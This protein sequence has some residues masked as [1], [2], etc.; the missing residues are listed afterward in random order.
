MSVRWFTPK[1]YTYFL[2][3]VPILNREPS[4]G[5]NIA[6]QYFKI[7]LSCKSY[8]GI[9]ERS[10][11]VLTLLS[12]EYRLFLL[13]HAGCILR[14]IYNRYQCANSLEVKLIHIEFLSRMTFRFAYLEQFRVSS[15]QHSISMMSGAAKTRDSI[16]SITKRLHWFP[17][18]IGSWFPCWIVKG[19]RDPH[20]Q[21]NI[22]YIL[23]VEGGLHK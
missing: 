19:P 4:R 7:W 5:P 22:P 9:V 18:G 3:R 16:E 2:S 15:E 13:E 21:A 11:V 20:N 1:E 12:S 23:I 10:E 14:D 8:R 17:V 6:Q